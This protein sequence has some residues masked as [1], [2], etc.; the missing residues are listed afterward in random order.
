ML[1]SERAVLDAIETSM[2]LMEVPGLMDPLE[3][4][5]VRGR[6]TAVSHPLANLVGAAALD[7]AQADDTIR[8]VRDGFAA[9]GKA[10]G[11]V[12]GPSSR[13]ADLGERLAAAGLMKVDEMA[14]MVLDDLEDLAAPIRGNPEVGVEEVTAARLRAASGVMARAYGLPDE[15]AALMCEAMAAASADVQA[16]GYLA[17]VSGSS[18]PVAFSAM[19]SI[20]GQPLVLLGG[21][22]TLEEHRGT[23][24]Y[25][26]LVARRLA[27]ARRDGAE[28]AVI[29][30]VRST[31]APICAKLG[32]REV[33]G[34]E[35]YAW[36]PDGDGVG[37]DERAH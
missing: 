20:P 6:R 12:T 37:G 3:V 27:D 19:M 23:G 25:T 18:E 9:E 11:W 33:C 26:S 35:L 17:Y 22:A 29:Q 30:A 5:G 2:F 15:V 14:G 36:L 28:A 7:E 10:F 34:L 21:A 16:R 4:P 1:V 8:A 32:F 13:P 31:S 24:I